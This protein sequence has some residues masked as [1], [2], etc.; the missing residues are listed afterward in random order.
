MKSSNSWQRLTC[1]FLLVSSSL[2]AAVS[3]KWS[4]TVLL[5]FLFVDPIGFCDETEP[6]RLK[7]KFDGEQPDGTGL[8]RISRV[9]LGSFKNKIPQEVSI[10]CVNPFE[11]PVSIVDI[12]TSCGCSQVQVLSSQAEPKGELKL[13]MAY[14]PYSAGLTNTVVK[15][16]VESPNKEQR[17]LELQCQ[18]IV[19][20]FVEFKKPG[21]ITL[22]IDAS[23]LEADLQPI[24]VNLYFGAEESTLTLVS[25]TYE[26]RSSK[27]QR[28]PLTS[29]DMSSWTL[30]LGLTSQA[31]QK[32]ESGEL[33]KEY[34][35]DV[36]KVVRRDANGLEYEKELH[37]WLS[38]RDAITSR[39]SS[40]IVASRTE[41]CRID[42]FF[43]KPLDFDSL[44]VSLGDS[45]KKV[46]YDVVARSS[47]WMRLRLNVEELYDSVEGAD[48]INFEIEGQPDAKMSIALK[49]IK[50]K[51]R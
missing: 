12:N 26:I 14:K 11:F 19:H 45:N 35:Q 36:F 20:D 8:T 30:T 18:G 33:A 21:S 27:R 37:T 7:V 40:I 44:K 47:R 49:V 43:S 34:F 1:N 29:N 5:L 41:E 6:K 2:L 48:R 15:V 39:I 50:E 51:P 24:E 23:D 28:V 22:A 32:F 17:V 25:E 16:I 4:I 13:R 3:R 38:I 46:K 9:D 42:L 10:T 31:R